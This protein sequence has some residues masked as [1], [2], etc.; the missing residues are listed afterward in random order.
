MT[1]KVVVLGAGFGGVRAALDLGKHKDLQV[2]LISVS[3]SHCYNPDLYELASA[4]LSQEARVDF[5]KVRGSVNIP[6]QE[7]FTKGKVGIVIDEV[8]AADLSKKSVRL[9]SGAIIYYD[10]L[11]LALGSNT[12]YFNI[13]GAE[14][15]SHQIK[16][17]ED[18]LNI[19]NDLEEICRNRK[20]K[21]CKVVIAGGGFTG[22]ELAGSLRH[23]L[24]KLFKVSM[25]EAGEEILSGMPKWARKNSRKRLEKTGVEILTGCPIKKVEEDK[26]IAGDSEVSFDY[27]I[28]TAGVVGNSLE[29]KILG[30]ESDQ[31]GRLQTEKN[32][33]LGKFPEVFVI[34]DLAEVIDSRGDPVPATAWAATEE[35]VLAA[36]NILA[37]IKGESL[38]DFTP[39]NPGFVVSVEGMYAL[40]NLYGLKLSGAIVWFVKRLVALKY[41]LS[42]LPF[43]SAMLI[44]W[45]GVKI[46]FNNDQS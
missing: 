9:K 37:K 22:V 2:V 8:E 25:V 3:S 15:Y 18:A 16:S 35:G 10:F 31:H 21:P 26:L 29:G 33:S 23:F 28:W 41:F 42:I 34:G 4:R 32:L 17:A 40:T 7:I 38:A 46:S 19:R 39:V 43:W 5:D 44:W 45:R 27:L 12:N 11:I 30:V 20:D 6:L 14:K 1:K 36:K 24:P 13:E